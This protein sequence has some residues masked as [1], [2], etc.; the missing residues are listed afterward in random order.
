MFSREKKGRSKARE[1]FQVAP[2]LEKMEVPSRGRKTARRV[3]GWVM[4]DGLG[5]MGRGA[6]E[7]GVRGRFRSP[8][9][10]VSVFVPFLRK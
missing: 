6:G 9:I 8:G 3:C 7:R 1:C 2:S 4:L 5:F 10:D